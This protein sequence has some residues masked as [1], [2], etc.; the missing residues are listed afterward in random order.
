MSEQEILELWKSGID[1]IQLAEIYKRR[2]NQQVKVIRASM[3]HRHDGRFISRYE[4]LAT[5]ERTIY[6]S[7]VRRKKGKTNDI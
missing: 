1:K 3:R 7:I 5:V 4:A 6:K 2:H